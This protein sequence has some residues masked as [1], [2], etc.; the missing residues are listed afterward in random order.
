VNSTFDASLTFLFDH[1]IVEV[2]RAGVPATW[3][4]LSHPG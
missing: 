3:T 4:D 2:F 1:G